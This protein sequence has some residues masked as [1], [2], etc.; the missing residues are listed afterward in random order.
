MR[1]QPV[2]HARGSVS[3]ECSCSGSGSLP[4]PKGTLQVVRHHLAPMSGAMS[5]TRP[6]GQLMLNSFMRKR[7]AEQTVA[8]VKRVVFAD[9]ELDVHA[10]HE[11]ELGRVV[12]VG[13]KVVR[14]NEID[15]L[16]V[17]SIEQILEHTDRAGQVI[18]P[19]DCDDLAK[20][21]WMAK[22]EIHCVI[23]ADTATVGNQSG[24]GHR[25]PRA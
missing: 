3:S 23:G 8:F 22:R 9:G 15:L 6:N 20:Q 5:F 17:I 14:R 1:A 13:Q 18:A 4:G 19:A 7:L 24:G 16:I 21:G 10:A 2:A 12:Q 25:F 11:V